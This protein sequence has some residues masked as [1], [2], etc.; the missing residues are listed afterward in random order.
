M[1]N[2]KPDF[3]INEIGKFQFYTGIII[4]TAYSIIFNILLRQALIVCNL[5]E[6]INQWSLDYEISTYYFVLIGFS[7]VSFSFCFTTYLWMSKPFANNRRRTLKLRMAQTNTIWVLFGTLLFL[8]RMFWFIA[9]VDLTIEQD[10]PI[11]GFMV[12]F[13]IYLYCWNL[14]SNIYK[15]KRAFFISL[16]IFIIGVIILSGI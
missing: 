6:C 10:F 14:I 9:G 2:L 13:F 3:T 7:S 16:P 12:P 15:S 5:G 11:L 8:L 1:K 4:G